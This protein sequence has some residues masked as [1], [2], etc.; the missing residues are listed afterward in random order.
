MTQTAL[1]PIERAVRDRWLGGAA[2]VHYGRCDDCQQVV[3]ENGKPQLV[4]RQERCR[5]FQCLTCFDL[6]P[7]G[8]A[9][10]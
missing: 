8:G 6:N 9:R 1:S 2:R 5:R 7:T 10:R 3:D 4:A